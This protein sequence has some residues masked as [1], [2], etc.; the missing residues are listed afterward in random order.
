MSPSP[1]PTSV[2]EQYWTGVARGELLLQQCKGCGGRQHYPRLLCRICGSEDLAWCTATGRGDVYT[3]TVARRPASDAFKDVVPYVC[4]LVDL[5]EGVRV[6][7]NIVNCDVE[8]M[9]I[10]MRVEVVF[11]E[12]NGETAAPCFQP[13]ATTLSHE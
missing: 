6:L 1:K 4:A 10:G 11:D 2:T 12:I 7:S 9:N 5:D 13:C 8:D 3:Y